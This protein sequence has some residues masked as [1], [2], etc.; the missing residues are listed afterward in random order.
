MLYP[1]LMTPYYKYAIWGGRNLEKLGKHLPKTDVSESWEVSVHPDGPSRIGNGHWSGTSLK[2]IIETLPTDVM[3]EDIAARY[4]FEFPLLFKLIDASDALSVQVHPGDAY[5]KTR[6]KE[7]NG[8]HEAWYILG[9]AP[10]A[11]VVYGLHP[12]AAK[13]DLERAIEENRI[14]GCLN[15]VSVRPGDVIDVV[16]GVV[17]AIGRGILLAE[18]QQSCNLTYRIYDYHRTDAQN[19]RRPLHI[20]K[21]LDVIDYSSRP[22][23]EQGLVLHK[24][25]DYTAV[26]MVRNGYFAMDILDIHG[27]LND[28][29]DGSRFYIVFVA[30]GVVCISY[31][32][33]TRCV[34][35]GETVLLPAALGNYSMTGACRLLKMYVPERPAEALD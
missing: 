14:S 10:G 7:P 4:H 8:K 19:N 31:D 2:D 23:V 1:F 5:A 22:A 34:T 6:E 35:A 9:A 28:R 24:G 33:G 30:Q 25:N 20:Q 26:Q 18:I 21:A 27:T 16:P 32:G 15:T 11:T 13:K 29:T 12:G 3:G 17:H